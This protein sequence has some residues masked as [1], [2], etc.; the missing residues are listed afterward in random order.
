MAASGRW[1]YIV[2]AGKNGLWALASALIYIFLNFY[3]DFDDNIVNEF[4][5]QNQLMSFQNC[6]E[7]LKRPGHLKISCGL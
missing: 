6:G 4:V 1:H 3:R 5:Q 7:L 2:D